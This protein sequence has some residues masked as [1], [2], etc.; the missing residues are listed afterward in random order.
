[1]VH[2]RVLESYIKFS[3]IYTT[4]HIFPVIPIKDMINEDSDPNAP[5]KIARGTKPSVSHLQVIFCPCVV[6][7]ATAHVDIK[8]LNMRDQA[9]KGFFAVSS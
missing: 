2:A 1:M 3:L 7:K 9:Q 8:A 6:W 5:L 4:D